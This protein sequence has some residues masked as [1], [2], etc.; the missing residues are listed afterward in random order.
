MGHAGL[1]VRSERDALLAAVARVMARRGYARTTIAE[2]AIEAGTSSRR[3]RRELGDVDD[4]FYALFGWTF[5]RAYGYVLEHTEDVPWPTSV[6]DGLAAFLEL[7]ASAPEYVHANLAGVRALGADGSLRVEAAVEAFTAFLTPGFDRVSPELVPPL[8]SELIGMQVLHVIT[9]HEAQGR[10][11][12]LPA[13]L[14]DLVAIALM[15]F[16][17]TA[18]IDALIAG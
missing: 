12:E 4:C 13:T 10:V 7:L 18:D 3:I 5:H 1:A 11:A 17:A 9:Q 16:C 2:I 8:T 6:R 14:P 15:P